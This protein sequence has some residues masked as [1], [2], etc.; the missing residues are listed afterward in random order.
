MMMKSRPTASRARATI[1]TGSRMRFPALPPYRS[2]R[3]LVWVTRN[4]LMK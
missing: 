2:V 3:R 1:S 4:W